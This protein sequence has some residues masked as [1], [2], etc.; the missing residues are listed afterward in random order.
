[1]NDDNNLGERS[2]QVDPEMLA[3]Q[4]TGSPLDEDLSP[5]QLEQLEQRL[6]E[7]L[8]VESLDA[9][10][11]L[12]RSLLNTLVVSREPVGG[13]TRVGFG[14]NGR[15]LASRKIALKDAG[16]PGDHEIVDHPKVVSNLWL[17]TGVNPSNG[18]EGVVGAP[19]PVG[20][21][22]MVIFDR[23]A[24]PSLEEAAQKA[25]DDAGAARN[26]V[27]FVRESTVKTVEHHVLIKPK[28]VSMSAL[29]KKK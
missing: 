12:A 14:V 19:S 24:L 22:P 6:Q 23:R 20:P 29:T 3:A 21:I 1:M 13:E 18:D 27:H 5:K 8:G 11:L 4:L 15:W 25:A 17:L 2:V 28:L 26:I 10:E 9:L 16:N 7:Q